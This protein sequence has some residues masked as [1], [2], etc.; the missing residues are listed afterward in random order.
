MGGG[1][2]WSSR[3]YGLTIDNLLSVDIVTADGQL[4]TAN[5]TENTDLFLGIRGGGGNFGVVTSFEYQLHPIG[6]MMAGMVVFPLEEAKT[7]LH[8]YREFA[9]TAPEEFVYDAVLITMPD[10]TPVIGTVV[11]YSGSLEEGE[12]VLR[13]LKEFGSP[14]MEQIGRM[15]YVDFQTIINDFYPAG[16]HRYWKSSFLTEVSDEVIETMVTHCA[17]RPSP[18][19]HGLIEQQ[20]GRAM[21]R[22]DSE[23]QPSTIAMLRIAS[24]LWPYGLTRPSLKNACG[25]RVSSGKR[26]SRS[27]LTVFMSTTWGKKCTK[28][29]SESKRPMV[30]KSLSD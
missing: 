7:V 26:C 3:K 21:S 23:A 13:P 2:G 5:A 14:M 19:C 6:P 8:F 1:W 10:G 11:C 12:Q 27:Q 15:A 25:G 22:V 18:M 9:K 29:Q 24:W 17:D 4:R 20:L 30:P 16:L 28:E